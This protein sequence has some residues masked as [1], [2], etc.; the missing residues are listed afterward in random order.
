M[1]N[2]YG[3]SI[4]KN[5]LYVLIVERKGVCYYLY[6]ALEEIR[7]ERIKKLERLEK[8]GIDIF[9]ATVSKKREEIGAVLKNFAKRIRLTPRLR[10][11]GKRGVVV[12]GR[13]F[14]KREHGGSCFGDLKDASGKIQ[15]FFKED[16]LGK[17]SYDLFIRDI[18]IG[19]FLEVSGKPFVTKRGEQTIEV[20][21]WR[22]LAKSLR[23]LPEKWHGLQDVEERFRKRY[24]DLLMNED[25]KAKF[26]ARSRITRE[27]RSF[28]EKKGFEE[29]ETPMLQPI[30]G[31]ALAKPFK[32][33]HNALDIDLYLRIAPE[34]FLKRLLVG[35]FE[36]VYELG[37]D[38]RNEGIDVTHN[39]EFTMLEAYASWWDEN[40]M[41]KFVE[42][43]FLKL[44]KKS[45]L[46]KEFFAEGGSASRQSEAR[47][48]AAGGEYD[49]SKILVKAP[50]PRITFAELLK[51]YALIVDYDAETRD[52]MALIA[53]RFGLDVEK[54]ESKGK[55]AD[56]IY[57]KIC[58]PHL[59]NPVFVVS[60]P[61]D[62]SPLAKKISKN[63]NNVRRFQLIVGDLEIANGFSEL[64]DPIDQKA[65]FEEQEKMRGAPPR[66]S[67]GAAPPP[68]G[69]GG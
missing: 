60:H 11:G 53:R 67:G 28:L 41:M 45:W 58:R 51:K 46:K 44:F 29:F 32:T 12:A 31:G 57:K 54:H 69:G 27:L 34:L 55:I 21:E 38:F 15:V 14:A 65:R 26:L 13:L 20:L 5:C 6:M 9:P 59:K 24:L 66:L 23:P 56:E 18:D 42:E 30:A 62:I 47:Q 40:D 3:L 39:P 49:G 33:H 50:F 61:L 22:I 48:G 7:S 8:A 37:R 64:N 68:R 4:I 17:D 25:V 35:G 1:V 19:D 43:M 63:S 2:Y 36:K 10:S 16:V 52:S